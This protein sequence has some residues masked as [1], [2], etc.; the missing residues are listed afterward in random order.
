MLSDKTI[1]VYGDASVTLY[2]HIQPFNSKKCH[3]WFKESSDGTP[4]KVKY[5][6]F[7]YFKVSIILGFEKNIDWMLMS[8]N[9]VTV[10]RRIAFDHHFL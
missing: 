1:N 2:C 3:T 6:N 8:D 10:Y 7:C 5:I 9:F 4:D